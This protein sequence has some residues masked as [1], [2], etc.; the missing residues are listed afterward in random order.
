VLQL[1]QHFQVAGK[2][3][4]SIPQEVLDKKRLP[5]KKQLRRPPSFSILIIKIDDQD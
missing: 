1:S 2:H 3:W 5:H 4:S